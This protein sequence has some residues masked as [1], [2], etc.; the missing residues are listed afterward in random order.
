MDEKPLSLSKDVLKVLSVDTRVEILK[1][2]NERQMTASELSRRL[3]KHVTTIDEHLN[4]LKEA[5]LVERLEIAGKKW[6]Y[7]RLTRNGRSIIQPKS[8]TNIV[9]LLTISLLAIITGLFLAPTLFNGPSLITN[10]TSNGSSPS[11]GG[12][13]LEYGTLTLKVTDKFDLNNVT[14]I[15]ITIGA[16]DVHKTGADWVTVVNTSKSFNLI[17]L[18]GVEEFLGESNLTLGNYTQIRLEIAKASITINGS[19]QDLRI[20]SGEIK[21][22]H[23]FTIE[24]NKTTTLVLD[25]VAADS[26]VQQGKDYALKPTIKITEK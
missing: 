25:F 26:I 9:L 14:S 6:I 23:P 10:V 4:H 22:I 3:G 17:E 8:Y 12:N 5:G 16:V 20:P 7:Y 13:L 11:G 24:A 2:L 19:E 18:I 21:L 15:N 1:A